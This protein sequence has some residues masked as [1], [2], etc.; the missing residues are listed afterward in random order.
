MPAARATATVDQVVGGAAGGHQRDHRVDDHTFIDQPAD[1]R[2]TF[3]AL[4]DRQHGVHRLARQRFA[5]IGIRVD[6]G[7][8]GHMQAH[9][10]EQH[11]VTVSGAVEGAGA[12]AVVSRGFGFEQ[13]LAP[14]QALRKLLAHL[15]LGGVVQAR[16]HRPGG[17]EHTRQVAEV[18]RADQEAGHDL[19]ADAE[20]QGSVEHVVRERDRRAHGDRVAREQAQLHARAALGDAVAHRRHATG[21]LRRRTEPMRGVAD[22]AWKALVGLVRRQHVVVGGD[23]ADVRRLL[24]NDAQLVGRR[25]RRGG[26][27]EVGAAH[28]IGAARPGDQGV[29]ARQV[30]TPGGGAAFAD[31]LGDLDDAWFHRP[32]FAP[33]SRRSQRRVKSTWLPAASVRLPSGIS[34]SSICIFPELIP[35][36]S[37]AWRI[38]PVRALASSRSRAFLAPVR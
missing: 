24:G 6:E 12:G 4:G 27:R 3:A 29:D 36:A 37:R 16:A 38:A 30:G 9:R 23:D 5:Q 19:V 18:Q 14:D 35:L 11:L 15:R 25:Q 28:V 34:T 32:I 20:Q 21:D 7:R 26:M 17:H 13:L 33:A 22:H 1:R 2:E 10:F 31:A 8:T